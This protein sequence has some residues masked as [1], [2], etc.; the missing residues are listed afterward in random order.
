MWPMEL[1]G[2]VEHYERKKVWKCALDGERGV[3]KEVN[4]G[5]GHGWDTM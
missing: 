4:K 3:T 1:R 2:A 5:D